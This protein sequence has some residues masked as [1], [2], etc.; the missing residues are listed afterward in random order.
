VGDAR[1]WLRAVVRG[2]VQGVGF[3]FF[4]EDAGRSLGLDGMVRNLPGGEVEIEAEGERITLNEL[5]ERVRQGPPAS[6]VDGVD[7]EWGEDRGRFN[8]FRIR[9]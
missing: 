6:R 2:R 7:T 5:V 1:A 3:R 4:V 8:G 9:V